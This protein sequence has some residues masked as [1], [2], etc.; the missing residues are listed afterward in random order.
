MVDIIRSSGVVEW[1]VGIEGTTRYKAVWRME[2]IRPGCWSVRR[3]SVVDSLG[4]DPTYVLAGSDSQW[5]GPTQVNKIGFPRPTTGDP[6]V[7]WSHGAA[8]QGAQ[9][10]SLTA[11]GAPLLASINGVTTGRIYQAHEFST[12][13][14]GAY[15]GGFNCTHE[16][17]DVDLTISTSWMFA[18]GMEQCMHYSAGIPATSLTPGG[19]RAISIPGKPTVHS[20]N[21]GGL[22]FASDPHTPSGA[23]LSNDAHRFE[24]VV[25]WPIGAGKVRG[26]SPTWQY[27]LVEHLFIHDTAATP[28]TPLGVFKLYQTFSSG[29]WHPAV[30]SDHITKLAV[31][32]VEREA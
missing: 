4:I 1:T 9:G 15:A 12:P 20:V 16:V 27:A 25:S 8:N 26:G 24:L 23:V 5:E 7:G 32:M 30:S 14:Q 10:A 3:L 18:S 2:E 28:S 21:D 11:D 29:G 17:T 19:L 31:R 13:G 22:H 6:Y